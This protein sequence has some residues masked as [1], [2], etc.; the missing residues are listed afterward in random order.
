MV[1]DSVMVILILVAVG[2]LGEVVK[3]RNDR[4]T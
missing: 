2:I 1:H 3:N 4:R